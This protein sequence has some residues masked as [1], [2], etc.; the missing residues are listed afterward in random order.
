[1]KGMSTIF[2]LVLL[3]Y[4][5]VVGCV[6]A[7]QRNLMY[8]PETK[9]GPPEQY[10]LTGFLETFVKTPDNET[11]QL[12]HHPAQEGFPTI[13]YFHGNAYTLGDRANIYSQLVEKGFGVLALS[14]RGYGKSTGTPSEQGIYLD[15]RTTIGYATD[16]LHIALSRL[17]LYGE[18]LGTGVAVQM[19]TEYNVAMVILQSP[20]TSVAARAAEIYYYIPVNWLIKDKYYTINKIALVK[21]PLLLFHGERDNVIPIAHGKAVFAA[22]GADKQA[23][24]FP[25]T[26]HN[27]FDSAVISEHVLAFAK[28]HNLITR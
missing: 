7:F 12:W 8:H 2:L 5:L 24:F 14:Y 16:S 6:Y 18:S 13:V 17:I 19:A 4:V 23:F 1:M 3:V 27:D 15:A 28:T 21:A 10:H 20:Y 25:Q 11:I 26:G 9:V 22:A